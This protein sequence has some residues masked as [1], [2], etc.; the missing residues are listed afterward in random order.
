MTL[1]TQKINGKCRS[2]NGKNVIE[3]RKAVT[4]VKHFVNWM[5][6][7]VRCIKEMFSGFST[8]KKRKYLI[9]ASHLGNSQ[10]DSFGIMSFYSVWRQRKWLYLFLLVYCSSMWRHNIMLI[11]NWLNSFFVQNIHICIPIDNIH[12]GT[13][14]KSVRT[15]ESTDILS[16]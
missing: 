11:P 6:Y 4:V 13:S 7:I 8:D 10:C 9:K 3:I 15:I 12:I 16:G 14:T 5:I 2:I 1:Q